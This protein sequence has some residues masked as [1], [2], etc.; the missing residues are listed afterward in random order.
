MTDHNESSE[1]SEISAMS[2][3]GELNP[4]ESNRLAVA[5]LILGIAGY[6][7]C[8]ITAVIGLVM[9]IIAMVQNSNKKSSAGSNYALWGVITSAIAIALVPVIAIMAAIAFPVFAKSRE[10][11][12]T[13][14]C[15][16]NMKQLCMG[17][18]M[19]AND[20]NDT[21]PPSDKWVDSISPYIKYKELFNCPSVGGDYI[22]YAMN[23]NLSKTVNTKIYKPFNSVMIYESIRETGNPAGGVDLLPAPGRHSG[24]N[25]IGFADGHVKMVFDSNI[26]TVDWEP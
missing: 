22:C 4:P 24:A 3:A 9:G 18:M 21:L 12:R 14:E 13:T 6:I 16:S 17:M 19:Y 20:N 2:E 11:A 23:R 26:Q 7:T 15:M 25:S 8:G 5:S 10:A 1:N